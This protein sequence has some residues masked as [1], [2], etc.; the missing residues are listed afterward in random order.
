MLLLRIE[1]LSKIYNDRIVGPTTFTI[2]QGEIGLIVGPS[3]SGKSTLLDMIYGTRA[4]STG[5]VTVSPNGDSC[6]LLQLSVPAFVNFRRQA[7]RLCTQFLQVLPGKSGLELAIEAIENRSSIEEIEDTF[8]SLALPKEI[9]LRPASSYSGGEKQ[10]L[11]IALAALGKPHVLLLDEPFASLDFELHARVWKFLEAAAKQ[12]SA[13]LIGLHNAE[14]SGA[15][16]RVVS[17]LPA[18]GA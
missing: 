15:A 2:D 5:T 4:A 14:Y 10:R 6:D 7:L 9:W 8:L 18:A 3:G 11:N 13:L 16:T 12:G 17:R 1:N